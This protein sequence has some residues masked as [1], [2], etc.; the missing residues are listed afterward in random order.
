MCG[1]AGFVDF[2]KKL[3]L[4]DLRAMTNTLLHRG[5]DGE[6]QKVW[7][8]QSSLVG[9][10]HRRLAIIDLSDSGKQPMI[11]ADIAITFNGEIYNYKELRIELL[12]RNYKFQ[13]ESDTEVIIHAFREWG[14]EFVHK[15]IGMFAFALYDMQ[16]KCVFFFRDRSGVKP[17]YIYHQE[18]TIL[19]ASELKAFHKINTFKKEVDPKAV[20]LYFKYGFIPNSQC[21]FKNCAKLSPGS[22]I[23]LNLFD[24]TLEKVQYWDPLKYHVP[25]KPVPEKELLD[26][27]EDLLLSAFE[28]RMVSDV[29]VGVFLSGGYDSSLVTAML[30]KNTTKKIKTFNIGF[31]DTKYDE[32]AYAKE[33][34]RYL[35]TEHVSV[36]CDKK[37]AQSII[38]E[39][40]H[41]YDEPLSDSSAIPTFLVSKVTSKYVKVA[42]SADGADEIFGGY[43]RNLQYLDLQKKIGLFPEPVRKIIG[44]LVSS[45]SGTPVLKT[46][47]RIKLYKLGRLLGDN[48]L[49]NIF[50]VMPQSFPE[51]ILK[52]IIIEEYYYDA[53][54]YSTEQ[55]LEIYNEINAMLS[56]DYKSTLTN[57]MLVKV[58][59]ATMANSLEGRE[60]FVDHRIYEFMASV[61]PNYKIKE[62]SLKY[63]LKK[64]THKYIPAKIM[65]RPKQGFGIPIS[66]WLKNDLKCLVLDFLNHNHINKYGILNP[67]KVLSEAN[68]HM[69]S[70]DSNDQ[71]WLLLNFQMWCDRWL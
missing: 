52:E 48:S 27:L 3:T 39:L 69:Y 22:Y 41:F 10:G 68:K 14:P 42:L 29:P 62:Q 46:S 37:E 70:K 15:L 40:T 44:K 8:Q 7:S 19:F 35:G 11:H 32:S 24:K 67:Q 63:I 47:E 43:K 53:K 17:L 66:Y 25:I 18:N 1:I 31:K 21:I 54:A 30:Q 23:K 13:T 34:A 50:E 5:P 4:V 61:S 2:T 49:L 6:G 64:L 60:P 20:T 16:N 71:L 33:I 56:L 51:N 57:D 55:S 12:K 9:F 65:D 36:I 59:R 28:Y 58:D 38:P 26:Q 45:F